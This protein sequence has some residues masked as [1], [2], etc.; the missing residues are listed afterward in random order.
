MTSTALLL[1]FLSSSFAA[2]ESSSR[3]DQKPSPSDQK[4]ECVIKG[5]ISGSGEKIYH[6]PGQRF[7]DATKINRKKGERWFCSEWEAVKAGWRK[8]KV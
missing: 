2:Q 6:V 1:C 7:Y 4:K 5:N 3:D 8:A